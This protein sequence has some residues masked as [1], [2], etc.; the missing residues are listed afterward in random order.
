MA[1]YIYIILT[2]LLWGLAPILDKVALKGSS[3]LAGI[4]VR[5]LV[6]FAL[7]GLSFPWLYKEKLLSALSLRSVIFFIL[8]GICAGFL[9][10]ITYYSALKVLP[11][12]KVVPLCSTYPLISAVLAVVFLGESL[13]WVRFLGIIL[14]ITGIFLVK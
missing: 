8:S 10:M 2:V 13:T 11:S 6:V 3:P 9:G 12:S 4:F 5:T 7:I 1:G 14:I